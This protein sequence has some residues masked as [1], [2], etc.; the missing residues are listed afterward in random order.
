MN[1]I[2]IDD[3]IHAIELLKTYISRVPFLK[4]VCATQNPIE[5]LT[6]IN[7]HKPDLVFLDIH[8][9]ELSGPEV[10]KLIKGSTKVI[11]T[12]A[13]DNHAI[14]AYNDGVIDYLLKPISFERFM[15]AT[16]K[17]ISD[18]VEPS[19]A[20][21]LADKSSIFIKVENKGKMVRL[22]F[23]DI[24]HV[25]GMRNYI[26]F[27]TQNNGL[28]LGL[29]TFKEVEESLPEPQFVRIHKS[30]IIAFDRIMG[31]DGNEV[32]IKGEK[33]EVKIPVGIT[34][35][36]KFLSMVNEVGKPHNPRRGD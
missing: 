17:A 13:Y 6:F 4:L 12:T 23:E 26:G 24:I 30:H 35:K 10:V 2:I 33:K 25:E 34:Y 27:H 5:G 31:I 7:T 16:Q 22:K 11:F 8:M 20:A 19:N 32:I 29:L 36:E 21:P 9:D 28:I 3:E 14:E 15:R 18:N 1:C